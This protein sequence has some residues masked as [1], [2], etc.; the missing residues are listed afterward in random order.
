MMPLVGSLMVVYSS[1]NCCKRKTYDLNLTL[2]FKFRLRSAK[3]GALQDRLSRI[4]TQDL[5]EKIYGYCCGIAILAS[6][7]WRTVTSEPLANMFSR[8]TCAVQV[9]RCTL[10]F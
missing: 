6:L 2:C 7:L 4:E 1:E 5:I 3:I 9:E 10:T 8:H